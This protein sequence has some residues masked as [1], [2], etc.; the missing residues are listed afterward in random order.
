MKIEIVS[1]SSSQEPWFVDAIAAYSKKISYFVD[2]SSVHLKPSKGSRKAASDKKQS[3]ADILQAYIKPTDFIILCDEKGK[4][5]SS[6][7]FSKKLESIFNSGSKRV[8]FII[9]GPYGFPEEMKTRAHLLLS[10]SPLTFN[11]WLAEVVMAEQ[12]Y[13]AISIQKNLPYHN[14]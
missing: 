12:I 14:E 1:V 9:G 10:L 4:T 5:F 8:L 6:V 7:A 2:F 11:H 13:R 3:D